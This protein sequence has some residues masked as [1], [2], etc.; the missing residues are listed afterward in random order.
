LIEVEEDLERFCQE[1]HGLTGLA[2]SFLRG[3]SPR[4]VVSEQIG[5]IL[6]TLTIPAVSAV[7]RAEE[8][9][10]AHRGMSQ[11][12]FALAAFRAERGAY[13]GQ[14]KE[15]VPRFMGKLPQ[16]PFGDGPYRYRKLK[17]GFLLYS[18]G[19]NRLDDGGVSVDDVDAPED[20][21]DLVVRF[22]ERE[23]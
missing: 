3:K 4:T 7:V 13:P 23:F 9:A 2:G 21:D 20:G 10:R 16:D 8:R 14:L 15:L 18:L 1:T 19:M 17:D 22:P 6:L 5:R 11:V 12:T